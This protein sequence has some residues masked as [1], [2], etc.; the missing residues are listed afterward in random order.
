MGLVEGAEALEVAFDVV[1]SLGVAL[2]GIVAGGDVDIGSAG[3][4]GF[5]EPVGGFEV[6]AAAILE[7][8]GGA[9][10]VEIAASHVGDDAVVVVVGV[11]AAIIH[12]GGGLG[13]AGDD[14]GAIEVLHVEQLESAGAHVAE[15]EA[16]PRGGERRLPGEGVLVRVGS[17]QAGGQSEDDG[18]GVGIED[19]AGEGIEEGGAEVFDFLEVGGFQRSCWSVAGKTSPNWVA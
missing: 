10:G 13:H 18:T 4:D 8:I 12:G 5:G 15:I 16:A 1:C 6:E 11:R 3:V 2:A 17:L 14:G 19:D 7:G 9:G